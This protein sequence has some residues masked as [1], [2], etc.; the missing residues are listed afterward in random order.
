MADLTLAD[1][2]KMRIAI[3]TR[4]GMVARLHHRDV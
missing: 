4:L 2:H 1:G 3:E